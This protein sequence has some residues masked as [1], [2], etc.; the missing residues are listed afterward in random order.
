MIRDIVWHIKETE[1]KTKDTRKTRTREQIEFHFSAFFISHFPSSVHTTTIHT[2]NYTNT[3][4]TRDGITN[5]SK[6]IAFIFSSSNKKGV[7]CTESSAA[8]KRKASFFF[9]FSPML[10]L[11]ATPIGPGSGREI[12]E[13]KQRRRQE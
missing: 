5:P 7:S 11:P 3:F 13:N 12:Q 9:F 1:V 2:K 8:R 6:I 4:S 10:P